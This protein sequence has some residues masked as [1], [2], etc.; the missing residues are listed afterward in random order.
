[1]LQKLEYRGSIGASSNG[2][3]KTG[4][5]YYVSWVGDEVFSVVN[6]GN[7]W[8]EGRHAVIWIE[9]RSWVNKPPRMNKYYRIKADKHQKWGLPQGHPYAKAEDY[10]AST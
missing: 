4:L 3:K 6:G 10:L 9:K 1:M 2:G 8:N 7:I 5:N